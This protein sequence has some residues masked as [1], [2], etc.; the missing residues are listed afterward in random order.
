MMKGGDVK[1]DIFTKRFKFQVST[2]RNGTRLGVAV[3]CLRYS[4]ATRG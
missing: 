2:L 4:V 1:N 3:K